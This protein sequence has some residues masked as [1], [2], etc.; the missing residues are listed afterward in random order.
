MADMLLKRIVA[1]FM[2]GRPPSST[3]HS[4]LSPAIRR[5]APRHFSVGLAL[6]R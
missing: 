5:C 6:S 2:D 3:A 4:S 1:V